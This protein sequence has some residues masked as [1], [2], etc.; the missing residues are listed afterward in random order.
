MRLED[1]VNINRKPM[2]KSLISLFV[3]IHILSCEGN[4]E[5]KKY[6]NLRT[7]VLEHYKGDKNPLKEKAARFLLDNLKERYSIEGERNQ[8]YADTI[9]KYYQNGDT[10][11]K[12]LLT[13]RPGTYSEYKVKDVNIL[14]AEYLIDNIDRSFDA[15]DKAG[16]KDQVSFDH[17]CEYILPYRV[18]NEPLENWRKNMVHDTLFKIVGK[19]FYSFTDLK[20]AA[21]WFVKKH[22]QI[23]A[24]FRTTWGQNSANIPDLQYSIYRLLST[25][26]CA[27]QSKMSAFTCRAA[28]IPITVD[29]TPYWANYRLGHEWSAIITKTGSIPFNFPVRDTLGIYKQNARIPS[30]I[31]RNTFSENPESH[32]KQ[33]GYCKFLP[34]VFNNPRLIDVTDLYMQSKN[35]VIPILCKHGKNEFAYLAVS[36]W[37][38]WMPVG[39]GVTKNGT[40]KYSKVGKNSVYLPVF[41]SEEGITQFNY[42]FIIMKT[43]EIRYLKPDF[44]KVRKIELLRKSP[45]SRELRL[46]IGQMING[47]F[48]AA[49]DKNFKNAVN[50]YT[51]TK[52]PDVYYNEIK[53]NATK[54]YRYVRYLG[55]DSSRCS[56]SEIE[57]Y[58]SN[59]T[60]PL[61][62]EIIGTKGGQPL[63]NAFD[64]D[65]LT[66]IEASLEP[67]KWVGLDLGKQEEISKIRFS[68]RNDKNHIVTDNSYELFYWDYEWKTLGK[69]TANGK[70][71]VY[72]RVPS[73][74]L[75][76]L[77]N[78]TEGKEERIFTIEDGKQVW[79]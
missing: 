45:L 71:L 58:A 76:L 29:F 68:S 48:Q 75:F 8:M 70:V 39:W 7:E 26:S 14:T 77:R 55:R 72:E 19:E 59:G 2:L 41:V 47:K 18:G 32:V 27:T 16:W 61:K 4:K 65:V 69:Q 6:R 50:L 1:L 54:K 15:W 64:G 43:G 36:D 51:I 17:F 49:N 66:Y 53:I 56:I 5:D 35:I 20:T 62:G 73:N 10:L 12:K 23:Y 28:G 37:L 44:E 42:P 21:S 34:E 13:L 52:Y 22:H 3:V 67:N 57:F 78:Y 9:R 63:K 38:T 46:N 30:K 31:Y 74:C 79:W 24:D 11:H 33:R 25:G 40:A 60:K